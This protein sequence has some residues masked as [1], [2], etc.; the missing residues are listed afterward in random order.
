KYA[1]ELGF[2]DII[3]KPLDHN[4]LK[5]SLAR[6]EGKVDHHDEVEHLGEFPKSLKDLANN[7]INEHDSTGA[8]LMIDLLETTIPMLRTTVK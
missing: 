6:I 7:L 3:S 4:R 2:F 1:K 8:A 5:S